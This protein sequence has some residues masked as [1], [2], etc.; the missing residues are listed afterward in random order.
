MWLLRFYFSASASL[1][2][3]KYTLLLRCIVSVF[4]QHATYRRVHVDVGV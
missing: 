3:L 1:A 2:L 4:G